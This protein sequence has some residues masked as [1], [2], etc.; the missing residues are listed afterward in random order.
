M[1]PPSLL[2]PPSKLF[3]HALSPQARPPQSLH[4]PTP[5]PRGKTPSLVSHSPSLRHSPAPS[6]HPH[7]PPTSNFQVWGAVRARPR[8]STLDISPPP[9]RRV[10]K[11]KTIAGVLSAASLGILDTFTSF[12]SSSHFL[13]PAPDKIHDHERSRTRIRHHRRR[14]SG[15]RPCRKPRRRPAWAVGRPEDPLH[16]PLRLPGACP[17]PGPTPSTL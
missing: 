8:T 16:R 11:H 6:N 15:P 4:A 12:C 3:P 7:R 10:R 13:P 1:F 17:G 9:P 14:H 2:F 5:S